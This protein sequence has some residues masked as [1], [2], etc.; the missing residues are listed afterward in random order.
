MNIVNLHIGKLNLCYVL[1]AG[2]PLPD[3]FPVCWPPAQ[4]LSIFHGNLPQ[5][6]WGTCFPHRESMSWNFPAKIKNSLHLSL[7]LIWCQNFQDWSI[8]V[9]GDTWP[10]CSAERRKK[11]N[12]N[13]N[14]KNKEISR[15]GLCA[16]GRISPKRYEI[17]EYRFHYIFAQESRY[18]RV[19][20]TSL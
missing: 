15:S 3:N 12:K 17:F 14:N 18:Q 7:A 6:I 11:K 5:K 10:S 8:P 4:A 19:Q 13:K 2:V 16:S 9:G 20:T 1:Y